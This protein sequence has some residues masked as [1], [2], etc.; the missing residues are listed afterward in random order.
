MN[1]AFD[2]GITNTDVVVDYNSKKKFFTFPSQKIN[3]SFIEEILESI[4]IQHNEIKNIAV[5]GGKSSDVNDMYKNIKITKVNEVDASTSFTFVILI[6][7]YISF[8]SLD[9]PP[10]TAIFLISL[11]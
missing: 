5:T 2:F 3:S 7:L 11:C 9:L 10:V 1:I 6:F 8:T 4:N